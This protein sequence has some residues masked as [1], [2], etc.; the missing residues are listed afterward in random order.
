MALAY[1]KDKN[2]AEA[3]KQ[4]KL[5]FTTQRNQVAKAQ[6]GETFWAD[7]GRA[8]DHVKTRGLFVEVKP[9]VDQLV[10]EYLRRNGNYRSNALL[11][12]AYVA[13]NDPA[14]ATAWLL[15]VSQAASD[16]TLVLQDIVEAT[17]IPLANRGPI[18][19]RILDAM[20][21]AT[22][23]TEG[24]EQETAKST[25]RN[26]QLRWVGYLVETKQYSQA[27]E[28]LAELRKEFPVAESAAL[29]PFELQCAASLGKLD[30]KIAEYKADPQ[31]APAA[32][33]LRTAAQKLFEAGD[34]QSARKILEFVFARELEEHQLVAANF[35]GLAEI[36]IADGDLPGAV[37]LLNR[38][39]LVVG[40]AYQNMDSS[41]TLLERTNHPV[42]AISFL[43]PLAKATPWEPSFRLRLAKAQLS[44]GQGKSEAA[45]I[46]AKLAAA[47]ENPYAVR[48]QAA[49]ALGGETKAGDFGS[50]E[51]KLLAAGTK[52]ITPAES[53]HPFF[54]DS[55]LVAAQNSP[56]SATKI[57]ILAK[58][59]AD[60]P[61]REEARVPFFRAAVSIPKDELALASIEQI[62]RSQALIRVAPE[63]TNEEEI[64][65]GEEE[66]TDQG[67]GNEEPSRISTTSGL[68]AAQ[69]AQVGREV[70]LAMMRLDRLEEAASYLQIA[71]KWEKAPAE[72]KRITAQLA[73]V[74]S[75]LRRQRAN[76]ARQP[77]L[78]AELEQD[79]LVR[80]RLAARVA[81]AAKTS[82]KTE[83]K[84]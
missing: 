44:A 3:I 64:I 52:N 71:Q 77:I 35:L 36:R 26:W 9:E 10:R 66:Q 25:L 81:A 57:E 60:Q 12:S 5:F 68:P 75:R 78:H 41:A 69:L 16:P 31:A 14:A 45:E 83:V 40:D 22:T 79:R 65:S 42:E 51:L 29:V 34:R 74:R 4:W 53:D 23:K 43:E 6:L 15:D 67:Q 47:A 27:N 49:L 72:K 58:A 20:Q 7:F 39:V 55:R 8:C 63:I 1:F 17:W 30:A 59:L 19:Q 13:Q 54:Y 56:N 84:P 37:N 62:L 38:L 73:E 61:S 82:G 28:A 24:L 80:P 32:E 46:L 18:L 50:A 21:A 33:S 76:A 70:G 48:V 11:H 2:R